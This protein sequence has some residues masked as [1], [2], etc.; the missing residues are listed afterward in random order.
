MCACSSFGFLRLASLI[1]LSAV[2]VYISD[3]SR[4]ST[5]SS[6]SGPL[7]SVYGVSIT[8]PTTSSFEPKGNEFMDIMTGD[9]IPLDAE[10][11]L[12][13]DVA[14]SFL[15]SAE[16]KTFEAASKG[17]WGS[18]LHLDPVLIDNA[19]HTTN[20]KSMHVPPLPPPLGILREQ[21]GRP[22]SWHLAA[23]SDTAHGRANGNQRLMRSLPVLLR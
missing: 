9:N 17:Q 16:S 22:F 23:T 2:L 3:A 6:L 1:I 12:S 7:G 18:T 21:D 15:A 8:Q 13:A 11:S 4:F 20:L 14:A 19:R 10:G 5:P